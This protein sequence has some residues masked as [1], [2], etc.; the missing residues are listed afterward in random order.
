MEAED[1]S[2][3]DGTWMVGDDEIELLLSNPSPER[4]GSDGSSVTVVRYCQTRAGASE[5]LLEE[6]EDAIGG[7][8]YTFRENEGYDTLSIIIPAE[9]PR[10]DSEEVTREEGYG[11]A[12]DLDIDG[13]SETDRSELIEAV[14]AAREKPPDSPRIPSVPERQ[15]SRL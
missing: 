8:G 12:Q 6:F 11:M 14:E 9:D 15:S 1:V 13:R 10:L 5:E 7:L 2:L 3:D 4:D